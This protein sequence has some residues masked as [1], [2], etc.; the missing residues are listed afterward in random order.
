MHTGRT[1]AD[2]G[3]EEKPKPSAS[4]VCR[5]NGDGGALVC[6]LGG[7]PRPSGR[8]PTPW[9]RQLQS[10]RLPQGTLLPWASF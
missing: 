5:Q 8:A 6:R 3:A 1:G 9:A 10:L 7:M 4:D 2:S